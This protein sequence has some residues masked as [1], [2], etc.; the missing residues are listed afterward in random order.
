MAEETTE[1]E[2]S[3]IEQS[4]SGA[5]ATGGSVAAGAGGVAVGGNVEGDVITG[6]TVKKYYAAPER[7]VD[8][9]H[10][11]PAPPA[12]FTGRE[13]ELRDILREIKDGATISG[14]RGLGGMGKTALALV[15]AERLAPDYPG[16][17]FFLDLKGA[18]EQQ[19]LSTIEA[20][21][22]VIQ[23]IEPA[24]KLPDDAQQI[25]GLYHSLLAG[26]K[27]LLLWDNARDAAQ[28]GPLLVTGGLALVTSRQHFTLPGMVR[29][30][31]ETMSAK[32]ARALIRRIAKRVKPAE[33]DEIAR[34]CDNLPLAMRVTASALA[35]GQD[36]PVREYLGELEEAGTRLG[37]VEASLKLSYDQLDEALQL[38]FSQLGVFPSPFER[39]AAAAVWEL[40]LKAA[41]ESLRELLN[42]SLLEYD[43]HRDRYDLHDLVRLFAVDRLAPLRLR[44]N[45][46]HL[47]G[48]RGPLSRH[49]D[50]YLAVASACD[51]EYKE[52]G[53]Y[54]LPALARFREIW[55][56]LAAAWERM[57]TGWGKAAVRPEG[58]QRWLAAFPDSCIHVL[59][60]FV[61]ARERI[62]FLERAARA[63]REIGDR[64]RE[65]AA[66]GNLGNAYAALGEMRKATEIYKQDL[67]I[68]GKLGDRRAE[69]NALGSLGIAYAAL[70]ETRKAIGFHD[71]ALVILREIGDR[72]AEGAVLGNLGNACA[73]LGETRKAIGFYEEYLTIAR[74]L[75]DR[76]AEGNA[77][78]NLGAAYADLG[79]TRKAIELYEQALAIDAEIG[80]RRGE[81]ALL[82]NL[83]VA[84]SDL[85]ETSKAIELY[86]QRLTIARELGDRRGEGAALNNLGSA[87]AALG[88]TRKAIE[89][90][91]QRLPTARELGD[92][93]SESITLGGLGNAYAALGEMRKAIE[94]YEQALSID[95][96]IG[97]RRGEGADLANMG[98]ALC[99]L[100]EQERGIAMLRQALQIFIEIESPNAE[101]VRDKLREWGVEA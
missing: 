15:L 25:A 96:E 47:G 53:E 54:I 99:K 24:A 33:A 36:L 6:G 101:W 91:E 49:A 73:A 98:D 62:V 31:L 39:E 42:R 56:H 66:L 67:K 37:L 9:L 80:D 23:S 8:A 43:E 70:G 86:E 77:L 55:P 65:S 16:G 44:P 26:K 27:A 59:D 28:V 87:F 63:A 57:A 69:G 72:R 21:R 4:G 89:F 61:P 38:R 75:G 35:E 74:E 58:A 84:Y 94:F 46:Q 88:E 52:G 19:P 76:Q 95:A 11:L 18:A 82:N 1:Q 13:K 14:I 32:G 7:K 48:V 97:D 64:R 81:G 51:D 50:Y 93:Q 30:D 68:A 78:G 40:D 79:D 92:R 34:L 100:G 5:T 10:Q 29:F 41:R 83:G 85:G 12:D 3:Q 60:S 71:Q 20:M 90:Y 17:Q 45:A 22:H 2:Q